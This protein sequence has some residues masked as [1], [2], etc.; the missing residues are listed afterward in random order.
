MGRP[1]NKRNFGPPTNGGSEI[2]VQFHN[3]T[4]SVNGWIVKQ[5]GSK[6][7]IC[8][9]DSA[10]T[11]ECSLVDVASA[12]LVAGEMSMSVK[13]DSAVVRRIT[14]I[15]SHK[16]TASDGSA[17]GWV[18]DD[19]NSDGYVEMEESG[20]ERPP[21]DVTGAS[22]DSAEVTIVVAAHDFVVGQVVTVAG[23]NPAGYD[24]D[25]TITG[26]TATDILFAH[27]E[28][29]AFVAGGTITIFEDD[30]GI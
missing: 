10:N 29:G 19:S 12:S 7:F 26:V 2:K 3:G 18:F 1:L 4:S 14:K 17:Y 23:M 9:D 11:A 24:G 6:R 21:L 20:G 30:F 15:A 22:G 13:D 28:V 25:Y 5:T 8:S 16:V 27:T